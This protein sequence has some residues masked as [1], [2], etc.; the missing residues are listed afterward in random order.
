MLVTIQNRILDF[1]VKDKFAE[2]NIQIWE[3][4]TEVSVI[5]LE[6]T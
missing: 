6:G 3:N 4:V 2:D 1:Q 5:V